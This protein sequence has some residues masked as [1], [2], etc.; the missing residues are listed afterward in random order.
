MNI[1]Q[2]L[3]TGRQTLSNSDSPESDCQALLCY[4]LDCNPTYLHTWRDQLLTGQQQH[5]YAD[6]LQQRVS[7]QPIAHIIGQRGFWSLDL[8][9]TSNTLIPRPDTETLVRI[10]LGK[11]AP[12][13]L[14]VDLG[15]GSGAIALA[16]ASERADIKMIGADYSA[17]ALAV[18]KE[19]REQCQLN[20][21]VLWQGDWLS[22][23][24]SRSLDMIVSNPPY[25]E[26]DDPH[27]L[28]GDVRFEP[29]S[30]LVSGH[31]GL[32][33]IRTIAQQAQRCLKPNA[34]LMIEHGYLQAESV[35][36]I[37]QQAGF[38]K[39]ETFKDYGDNDRVTIG[40]QPL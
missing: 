26:S 29:L 40:Q 34:W 22:A 7:G 3:A 10:A 24:A 16:L 8:K 20:H 1:E 33:D 14:I 4:A 12:E 18:A 27:L 5:N 37:F 38:V 28:Q 2:A 25:I 39:I 13:M 36:V 11:V 31:D 35:N 30:A 23:V 9:V 17:S 15:T 21:V 6:Y 32:D 19:N